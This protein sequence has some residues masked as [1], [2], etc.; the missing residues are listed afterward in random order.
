MQLASHPDP[1]DTPELNPQDRLRELSAILAAGVARLKA[2][3]GCPAATTSDEPAVV[4]EKA[5]EDRR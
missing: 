4:I 2:R 3:A 1:N 5:L